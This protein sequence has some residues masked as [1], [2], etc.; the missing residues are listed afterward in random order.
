MVFSYPRYLD[1]KALQRT[2]LA[3]AV[4]HRP[5][6]LDSACAPVLLHIIPCNRLAFNHTKAENQVAHPAYSGLY[7]RLDS[8]LHSHSHDLA[9][10]GGSLHWLAL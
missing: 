5:V 10:A 1:A 8:A 4:P 3:F 9:S 2:L 6:P 7:V